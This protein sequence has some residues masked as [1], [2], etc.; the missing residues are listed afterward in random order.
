MHDVPISLIR[1]A[2]THATPPRPVQSVPILM[3]MTIGVKLT[4]RIDVVDAP[5]ASL[6]PVS[7]ADTGVVISKKKQ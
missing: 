5:L 3:A 6:T 4:L 7:Y 1:A 2:T